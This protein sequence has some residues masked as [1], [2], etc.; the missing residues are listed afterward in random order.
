MEARGAKWLLHWFQGYLA[1]YQ[2]KLPVM[3]ALRRNRIRTGIRERSPRVR[4]NRLA[5][6][7]CVVDRKSRVLSERVRVRNVMALNLKKNTEVT[8]EKEEKMRG[9]FFTVLFTRITTRWLLSL[10]ITT[11]PRRIRFDTHDDESRIWQRS[12]GNFRRRRCILSITLLRL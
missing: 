3:E 4:F 1:R 7:D 9:I 5:S 11:R 2:C 6:R 10:A 8:V 12:L